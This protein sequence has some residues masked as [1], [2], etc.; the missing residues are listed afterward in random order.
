VQSVDK[1]IFACIDCEL[2]GLDIEKD[3]IIEVAVALFKG[4]EVLESFETLIDP[5]MPIPDESAKIHHITDLMVKG[6]PKI[7][8]I[9]PKI[10]S[11]VG[12]Y[13]VIGHGISFDLDIIRKAADRAHIPF[14][15]GKKTI[16]TF[17]LA[18]LYGESPTNSLDQLRHH[19][20][21]PAEGAHRALGDVIVNVQVFWYLAKQFKNLKDLFQAL[22]KPI[23]LKAMPLGKHKGRPFSE[24][25][26]SFLRWAV[27]QQFD[28]DLLF[29][30]RTELKK[31]KSEGTFN[32]SSNPFQDL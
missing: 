17:R 23:L 30:I 32:Q 1:E 25:P 2:T 5:G 11:M 20:N 31:R 6:K 10:V 15:I 13:T 21:I 29:S 8:D 18:R 14:P 24:L 26:I 19:F 28:E 3:R 9:I 16:D 22:S 7:E 27:H 12:D 4:N